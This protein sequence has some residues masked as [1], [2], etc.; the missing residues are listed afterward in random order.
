MNVSARGRSAFSSEEH[1]TFSTDSCLV[2]P[3][4]TPVCVPAAELG[5]Q[6]PLS[7]PARPRHHRADGTQRHPQHA[8]L[9]PPRSGRVLDPRRRPERRPPRGRHGEEASRQEQ[10]HGRPRGRDRH[11][12]GQA[13]QGHAADAVERIWG[14]VAIAGA[15]SFAGCVGS[16]VRVD[17]AAANAV[18]RDR[19][20]TV[21][22]PRRSE[23]PETSPLH[24]A[25]RKRRLERLE[26]GRRRRG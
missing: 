3:S 17:I 7:L 19:S 6:A 18:W 5:F 21:V 1:R 8:H 25:R 11:R 16:S 20:R 13:I 23:S 24:R 9:V 14:D 22:G 26:L 12:S 4:L 10:A 2:Y 15:L